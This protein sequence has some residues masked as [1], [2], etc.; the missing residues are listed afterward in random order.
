MWSTVSGVV[1]R[2][3]LTFSDLPYASL[4]GED[5]VPERTG[6]FHLAG[7]QD[8]YRMDDVGR[9]CKR[10]GLGWPRVTPVD[11]SSCLVT[12]KPEEAAAVPAALAEAGLG[13]R[14]TPW[15]DWAAVRYSRRLPEGAEGG[16]AA[17]GMEAG[18][19][20]GGGKGYVSARAG[21]AAKRPRTAME[22]DAGGSEQP[23]QRSC[24]IM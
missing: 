7:L 19:G 16:E 8:G 6:T 11:S 13:L 5:P 12:F 2:L 10:L 20:A 4:W 23:Q 21:R 22:A 9:L 14:L 3:N 15:A 1:G 17:A 18:G 24:A